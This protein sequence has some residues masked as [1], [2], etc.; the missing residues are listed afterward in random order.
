M[1]VFHHEQSYYALYSVVGW[2]APVLMTATWAYITAK[3][4]T[5]SKCWWGYNLT[6]YFWILEGPRL[7]VVVVTFLKSLCLCRESDAR[8]TLISPFCFAVELF[9]FAQHHQSVGG[10]TA[11]KSHERSGTS[12]V[13]GRARPNEENS[14]FNLLLCRSVGKR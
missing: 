14:P 11:T 4:Y 8:A 5:S 2:G 6:S 10:E 1:T 9:I 7:G 13:S 12:K 3:Y